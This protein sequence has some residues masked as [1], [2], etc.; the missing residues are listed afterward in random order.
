MSKEGGLT[1]ER[2]GIWSWDLWANEKPQ[3]NFTQTDARTSR[4]SDW[5]GLRAN[6]VKIPHPIKEAI[7]KVTYQTQTLA[8]AVN[9]V[10]ISCSI[11]I[12][13]SL[14][15]SL[16]LVL[17]CVGLVTFLCTVQGSTLYYNSQCS[18]LCSHVYLQCSWLYQ[19]VVEC[20]S[21]PPR[22]GLATLL[23]HNTQ[24]WLADIK[25]HRTTLH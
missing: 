12:C 22:S 24:E 14:C 17:L 9:Q 20:T 5:I 3:I 18:T 10:L 2:P 6:S 1:N 25:P 8:A 7:Q 21:D 4:L 23:I 16:L 15:W 11:P 13:S 19:S